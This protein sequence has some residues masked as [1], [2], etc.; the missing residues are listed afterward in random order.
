MHMRRKLKKTLCYGSLVSVITYYYQLCLCANGF[1]GYSTASGCL[2][3]MSNET[4]DHVHSADY[5]LIN[6]VDFNIVN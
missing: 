4:C 3:C 5:I 6:H 1:W 2:R